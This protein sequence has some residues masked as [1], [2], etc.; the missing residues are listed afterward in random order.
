MADPP[1]PPACDRLTAMRLL[2]PTLL[3]LLLPAAA[4]AD[5]MFEPVRAPYRAALIATKS[6]EPGAAVEALGEL[7][8]A[9]W[10]IVR[11]QAA[12][13]GP[14]GRDPQFRGDLERMVG[15][16]AIAGAEYQ[17]DLAAASHA[18]LEE[19]REVLAELRERNGVVH[20]SDRITHFHSAMEAFVGVAQGAA[21]AMTPE[22]LTEARRRFGAMRDAW[23]GVRAVEPTDGQ[24]DLL[25]ARLETQFGAT[26]AALGAGNAAAVAAAAPRIKQRYMAL[27]KEFG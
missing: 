16:A 4:R 15:I 17:A 23:A 8:V 21:T 19:F 7:D 12:A 3:L 10:A 22:Q 27:F 13:D 9:L 20:L 1:A 25:A 24:W 14:Y 6:P 18:T 5:D 11:G 26:E 2:L